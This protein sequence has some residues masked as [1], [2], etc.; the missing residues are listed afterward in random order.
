MLIITISKRKLKIAAA[1]ALAVILVFVGVTQIFGSQHNDRF[2]GIVEALRQIDTEAP[3]E[4]L[5]ATN[6]NPEISD[7]VQIF[8]VEKGRIVKKLKICAPIQAEAE[9]ILNSVTGL[10]VKVKPLPPKGYIVKIPINP[11]L[12]VQN[13]FIN[14][15]VDNIFI[16]FTETEPPILLL[17]DE[18][19][20]P[21]V[22]NF[23]AKTDTLKKYLNF[24]FSFK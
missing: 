7:E 9:K 6:P 16:I 23:S 4:I 10:Y 2:Q 13:Q 14:A 15:P 22:Y 20:K 3:E 21:F 12:M 8:D 1:A 11:P 5:T 24:N 19:G 18:N 17:L